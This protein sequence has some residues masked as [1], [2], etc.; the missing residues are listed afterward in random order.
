MS[1]PL[2]SRR[3]PSRQA[4]QLSDTDAR[5]GRGTGKVL[6]GGGDA[7]ARPRISSRGPPARSARTGAGAAETLDVVP[8]ARTAPVM[9]VESAVD[10]R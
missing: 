1:L 6:P 2:W 9:A 10:E 8:K 5:K 7:R 3:Q 4:C